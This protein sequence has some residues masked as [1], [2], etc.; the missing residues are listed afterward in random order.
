MSRIGI[1]E[2]RFKPERGKTLPDYVRRS[3]DPGRLHVRAP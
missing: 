3:G 2:T 1:T